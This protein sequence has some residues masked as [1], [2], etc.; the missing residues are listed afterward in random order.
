MGKQLNPGA[1]ATPLKGAVLEGYRV[2]F[3]AVGA[4]TLVDNGRSGCIT[5]VVRNSAGLYTFT[6]AV[7][8]YAKLIAI[9]PSLSAVSAAGALQ[10]ARYVEGSYSPTAGTFQI[11]VSDNGVPAAVEATSGT[12]LDLVTLFQR[13]TNI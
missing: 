7:P 1:L 3:G 5:T 6:L 11:A 10:T 13:L 4:P 2:T 8:Y 12:A 9:L